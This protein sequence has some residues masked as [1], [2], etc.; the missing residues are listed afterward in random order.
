MHAK[1][2]N[3]YPLFILRPMESHQSVLRM[4]IGFVFQSSGCNVENELGEWR[5][6]AVCMDSLLYLNNCSNK[7]NPN[8]SGLSQ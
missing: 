8:L 5:R 7:L 2:K 1:I 4:E 6:S 3:Y